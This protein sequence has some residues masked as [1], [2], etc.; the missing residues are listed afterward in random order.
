MREREI[1]RERVR[2]KEEGK[3]EYN[4]NYM[5]TIYT[6]SINKNDKL[7]SRDII[8]SIISNKQIRILNL[9]D[10]SVN[11]LALPSDISTKP[12]CTCTRIYTRN[13]DSWFSMATL[14][15]NKVHVLYTVLVLHTK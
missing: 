11:F 5:V 14:N 8:N 2:G 4:D 15:I 6:K 10:K 13:N 1:E 12:T 9:P 7:L 3:E